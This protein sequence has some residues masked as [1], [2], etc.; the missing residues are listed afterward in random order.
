[1]RI[2]MERT[3]IQ[4]GTDPSQHP[5]ITI[6]MPKVSFEG[7]DPDRPL[8]DIVTE[9]VEIKIHYDYDTDAARA[10]EI[11]IVNEVEKYDHA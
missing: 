4:I 3:D 5:K 6:D 11:T 8:D 9:G 7:W 2:E 1:M 10:I